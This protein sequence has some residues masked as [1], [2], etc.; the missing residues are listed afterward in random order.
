M[1]DRETGREEGWEGKERKKPIS[2]KEITIVWTLKSHEISSM[3]ADYNRNVNSGFT[4]GLCGAGT[5]SETIGKLLCISAFS[6][7]I[8]DFHHISKSK[9]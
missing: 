4:D 1:S 5:P 2:L 3:I 9:T 7:K 6:G 8:H